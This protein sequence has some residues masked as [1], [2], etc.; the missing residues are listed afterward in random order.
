MNDDERSEP[1]PGTAPSGDSIWSF[2]SESLMGVSR[3]FALTIPQ[4][5]PG[6]REAV[7]NGYLLCRIA[8][9][10]EDDP[11]MDSTAK[12]R[13]HRHFLDVLDGRAGAGGFAAALGPAL[14]P[15]TPA[16]EL[17]LIADTGRVVAINAMLPAGQRRALRR[18]VA[19]MCSGM[20]RFQRSKT[21]EGLG[22]LAEMSQY[23]YVVAGVV[24]EMLTDLFCLY[25]PAIERHRDTMMDLSVC[26][27][28]GLQ[29]TNILKDVWEDREEGSCWLP[30]AVFRRHGHDLGAL[31]RNRSATELSEGIG[32]LVAVAH[33][34]LRAALDYSCLIPRRE[35]GIR[36]FCLWAIGLAVLTLQ[37]IH[38][39]PGYRAG[40][41]VKV[42]RA[43]VRAVIAAT[44]GV[45]YSNTLLR[46]VFAAAAHG[47]PGTAAADGCEPERLRREVRALLP[48]DFAAEPRVGL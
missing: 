30:R 26:F 31:I 19:T 43:R 21:L 47:L 27:G 37:N 46:G 36:R 48:G 16:T 38:R 44:N 35:T 18:C 22:D 45:V 34:H 3:T 15:G 29:M 9:T 40:D 14:A 6:L 17:R 39:N 28:L 25:S 41:D 4:L 7:A 10:I 11:C 2:Q 24:G 33:G 23:C 20:P 42:S 8:D 1:Q 5:P 13:Y 32:D 12:S